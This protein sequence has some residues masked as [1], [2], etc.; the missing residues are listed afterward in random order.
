[1]VPTL[2]SEIAAIA[3]RHG[4]TVVT[5]ADHKGLSPSVV[6]RLI[7]SVNSSISIS[8]YP[9]LCGSN[10]LFRNILPRAGGCGL[11]RHLK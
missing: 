3:H 2:D 6:S 8:V 10:S 1:M 7:P 9:F 5:R 4:L 11:P